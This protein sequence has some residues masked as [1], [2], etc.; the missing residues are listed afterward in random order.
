[1]VIEQDR[2]LYML[3]SDVEKERVD[4]LRI[5]EEI[6]D[7]RALEP[8]SRLT[9]DRSEEVR[10][11]AAWAFRAL[12]DRH[13]PESAAPLT[14]AGED[15]IERLRLRLCHREAKARHAALRDIRP[16]HRDLCEFL[17]DRIPLE[18][19]S[20]VK[21]S[22]VLAA[23]MLAGP[24]HAHRLVACLKD[25]DARVRAN[26]IEALEYAGDVTAVRVIGPYVT[27]LAPRIRANACKALR[28]FDRAKV[29]NVLSG[30]VRSKDGWQR[31]AAVGALEELSGP[32]ILPP[33][34]EL[35]AA[36]ENL[37]LFVI[38]LA[39]I[40]KVPD[41][42]RKAALEK[43]EPA[44]ED[45]KKKDWLERALTAIAAGEPL[46]VDLVGA[47][48]SA[49][50]L[51]PSI[52]ELNAALSPKRAS[53]A[54][55]VAED[56]HSLERQKLARMAAHL[57]DD[58]YARDSK[59]RQEAAI[60]LARVEHSSAIRA[61][62][63]AL[64]HDDP[65]V[66]YLARRALKQFLEK[67]ALFDTDGDMTFSSV[68][69]VIGRLETEEANRGPATSEFNWPLAWAA[70]LFLMAVLYAAFGRG[71]SSE[72]TQPKP[73]RP[74]RPGASGA[75]TPRPETPAGAVKLGST[76]AKPPPR[77]TSAA[78]EPAPES[79]LPAAG[80]ID[81]RAAPPAE[82][83][84]KPPAGGRGEGVRPDDM[85]SDPPPRPASSGERPA[86]PEAS[87]SDRREE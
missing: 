20:H 83:G 29:Q 48:G 58:L 23:G 50:R 41:P 1:E 37:Y 69:A 7:E 33:L 87:V 38:A 81:P 12:K 54:H 27:D 45:A 35:A 75:R 42:G 57:R 49:S 14:E 8:V 5:L 60:K 56:Q 67:P 2:L 84:P 46:K 51:K 53:A 34:Y 55:A 40:S 73:K 39:A 9:S 26:A 18:T 66:K 6:G 52:E 4:A 19:D 21:A 43:L 63:V 61:L 30:M 25:E 44:L 28:N 79:K 24:A 3:E 80:V 85:P 15:E 13:S 32:E 77:D 72:V 59:V 62:T 17:L 86:G 11:H 36:E 31:A 68:K 16:S 82:E 74:K 78:D 76:E 65:V 47:E 71:T 64:S 10:Q 22:M 70:V